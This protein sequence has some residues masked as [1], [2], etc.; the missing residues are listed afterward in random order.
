MRTTP[1]VGNVDIYNGCMAETKTLPC[2]VTKLQL[3]GSGHWLCSANPCACKGKDSNMRTA[4]ERGNCQAQT[5]ESDLNKTP[6]IE[7]RDVEVST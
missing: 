5:A 4:M 2:H 3:A 1:I 6:A 7:A